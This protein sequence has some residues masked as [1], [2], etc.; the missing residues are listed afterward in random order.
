MKTHRFF[1]LLASLAL[2]AVATAQVHV[3]PVTGVHSVKVEDNATLKVFSGDK[4][5]IETGDASEPVATVKNG[6]MSIEG[7]NVVILRLNP[8]HSRLH[9]FSAED[10]ATIHFSGSFDF[11]GQ[12][13]IV[14]AEDNAKV[15]FSETVAGNLS[16]SY[17]VFDAQD[18]A[19]IVSELPL[20]VNAYKFQAVDNAYI[21]VPSVSGKHVSDSTVDRTHYITIEDNGQI[22]IRDKGEE[23]VY[24]A[25]DGKINIHLGGK[26]NNKPGRDTELN[27]FWGFNHWLGDHPFSGRFGEPN[28]ADAE[29]SF[30]FMNYGLSFDHPLVNTSHFGLY[31]GFGFEGNTYHFSNHLVS[32]TPTGFSSTAPAPVTPT[33]TIDPNNWDTYLMTIAL[34]VPITFSFE[35]WKYDDF[36]IRLSAIPGINVYGVLTQQY[37]SNAVDLNVRDHETGKKV[38][39]FMLDTRL[40][41]MYGN[42]GLYAQMAMLPLFNGEV[43]H[44]LYPVKFGLFLTLFGR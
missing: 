13:V 26:R 19:R 1:S 28:N 2:C 8:A 6:V 39:N 30:Y 21:E 33:G 42:F 35:P 34:T 5:Q 16:A 20:L 24:V 29:V 12:K 9:T 32:G 3:Q 17:V 37:E 4:T 41:L 27:W 15:E 22:V 25:R 40:T 7:N 44:G 36:C 38:S 23:G 31:A 43:F 14:T 18:N 11:S 10:G